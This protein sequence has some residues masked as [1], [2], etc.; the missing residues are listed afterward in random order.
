FIEAS[1]L[2]NGTGIGRFSLGLAQALE[3]SQPGRYSYYALGGKK[4]QM[5]ASGLPLDRYLNAWWFPRRLYLF[6]F[7]RLLAPKVSTL[8]GASPHTYFF[9]DF[10]RYRVRKNERSLALIYDLAFATC[11]EFLNSG[12]AR[13][14]SRCVPQTVRRSDHLIAISEFTKNEIV[15]VFQTNPAK[16]TVVYPG[17]DPVFYPRSEGETAAARAKYELPE[18]YLLFTG[19]LEPRKNL[20]GLLDVYLALPR[21]LRELHPLVLAGG[22]GWKD[23]ALRER[24]ESARAEGVYT[25]GYIDEADLPALYT[26]AWAFAYPSFYE[27]FG[28]PP[29]EAMAC[30]TPTLVSN[31][32][33]LPEAVGG[34][35]L[36]IDPDDKLAFQEA[37]TDLL[38][39]A[40][41]REDLRR[42]GFENTKR[43]DWDRSAAQLARLF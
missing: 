19:T 36:A 25:P 28:L 3:R 23:T 21:A 14:L 17:L 42:K 9:T 24:I 10:V 6:L 5:E 30:G 13:Y 22:R 39:N 26:G 41:L 32:A 11:P 31:R 15:R 38:Q 35:A 37:L 43:F 18:N 20:G 33:S 4:E 1:W 27:G 34:A 7:K 2:G 12:T 40:S 8:L 29:L 16:I